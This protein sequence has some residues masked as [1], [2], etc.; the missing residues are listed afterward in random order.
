[1]NARNDTK[2]PSDWS[3]N[4]RI[5]LAAAQLRFASRVDFL[6]ARWLERCATSAESAQRLFRT[7]HAEGR[8]P[9]PFIAFALLALI[10]LVVAGCDSG[11]DKEEAQ[12]ERPAL[13]IEVQYESQAPARLL[14]SFQINLKNR[15][16]TNAN[17]EQ[18]HQVR[19]LHSASRLY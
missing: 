15:H 3:L 11:E 1:M 5:V 6:V 12:P 7:P 9:K 19:H 14:L 13:T 17:H 10:S 16:G 8:V 2:R 18:L 4:A